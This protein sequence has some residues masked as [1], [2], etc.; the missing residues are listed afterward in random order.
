MPKHVSKLLL[1][2]LI[3]TNLIGSQS[4]PTNS[5]SSQKPTELQ[6]RVMAAREMNLDVNEISDNWP[7]RALDYKPTVNART[8]TFEHGVI[9]AS[10]LSNLNYIELRKAARTSATFDRVTLALGRFHGPGDWLSMANQALSSPQPLRR[11]IA[12]IV[13]H[14]GR[15]PNG[16]AE[17]AGVGKALP[18]N[19]F[20]ATRFELDQ[21]QKLQRLCEEEKNLIVRTRSTLMPSPDTERLAALQAEIRTLKKFLNE[22]LAE[23]RTYIVA[24]LINHQIHTDF[25]VETIPFC[26]IYPEGVDHWL[27]GH[28]GPACDSTGPR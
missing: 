5:S 10:I 7:M 16:L 26:A 22:Q 13:A 17:I 1:P 9:V 27:A 2:I 6:R 25:S 20:E 14:C 23:Q 28:H 3:A 21:I 11:S 19:L 8:H 18:Y 24:A 4:S 15:S 12:E